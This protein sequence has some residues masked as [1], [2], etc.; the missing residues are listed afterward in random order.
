MKKVREKSFVANKTFKMSETE[1]C[2]FK[3]RHENQVIRRQ[4]LEKR[5]FEFARKTSTAMNTHK[6]AQ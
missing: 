2:V 3:R 4:K 6:P 1:N 5:F